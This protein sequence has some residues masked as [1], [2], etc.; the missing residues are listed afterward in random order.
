[1]HT[2]VAGKKRV[3]LYTE[4]QS[5][6]LY[7]IPFANGFSALGSTASL[8]HVTTRPIPTPYSL[9]ASHA[10]CPRRRH[11]QLA[12]PLHSN[13]LTKVVHLLHLHHL[14]HA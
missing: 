5:R 9:R 6:F 2:V 12:W 7:D 13:P 10:A 14:L 1:M 8:H 4:D 11:Y 3:R